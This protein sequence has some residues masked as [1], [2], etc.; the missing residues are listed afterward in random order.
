MT[1]RTLDPIRLLPALLLT[2][3]LTAC[4][5]EN[6]QSNAN[7]EANQRPAPAPRV[8]P[9]AGLEMDPRVQFPRERA[10]ATPELAQS[11]AALASAIAAGDA[12]RLR[13]LVDPP[14]AAVLD[15]LVGTGAW[16]EETGAIEVGRVV[17][18]ESQEESAKV[19]LAVQDPR[20]AYLLGWEGS[21]LRGGWVF[22]GFAVQGAPEA[23]RAAQLDGAALAEAALPELGPERDLT[24]E[25]FRPPIDERQ[26]RRGSRRGGGGGRS[27]LRGPGG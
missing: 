6:E 24:P 14:T 9:M 11:V 3:A 20:G 1:I 26:R 7:D 21:N 2:L 4:G 15:E 13:E 19:G 10:P 16:Q 27:P 12:D 18:L 5:G 17:A 8:D 22:T 25:E 23:S